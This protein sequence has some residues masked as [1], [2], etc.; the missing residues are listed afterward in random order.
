MRHDKG[1]FATRSIDNAHDGKMIGN[2]E[3][4]LLFSHYAKFHKLGFKNVQDHLW[5][6]TS[7]YVHSHAVGL[8][9]LIFALDGAVQGGRFVAQGAPR[10]KNCLNFCQYKIK[11]QFDFEESGWETVY[12]CL[13]S[14]T[15][16]SGELLDLVQDSLVTGGG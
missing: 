16:A 1:M 11:Q 4:L 3:R 9:G 13:A 5:P 2:I 8:S 10:L 14:E 12:N 7:C 15:N 6:F